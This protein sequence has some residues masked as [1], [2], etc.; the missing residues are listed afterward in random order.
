MQNLR[1]SKKNRSIQDFPHHFFA[2]ETENN[3]NFDIIT[4]KQ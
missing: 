2:G 4:E 3:I 1:G